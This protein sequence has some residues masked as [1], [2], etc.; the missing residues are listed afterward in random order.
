MTTDARTLVADARR[1]T[2]LTGAGIST[3]SGIPDFRGPN[4]LWTANPGAARMFDIDAYLADRDLRVQAWRNRH[5]HPAWT[6]QPNAAHHAIA[7]LERQGRLRGLIT[8]NIDELHQA[9]GSGT[10]AP[11]MEVHGSIKRAMC[12]SCGRRVPMVDVLAR[13]GAG[14]EDPRCEVCHGILKSDTISFGQ[15]LDRATLLAAAEAAAE[16]EVFLAV[17]SSLRVNPVAGLV[18]LAHES[19]AAV[20][21]VNAEP[22]PYDALAAAVLRDPIEAV[23]PTLVGSEG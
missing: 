16:C 19:G 20:V 22:T 8:Q 23:L 13:V 17:G 4:G 18:P 6:A 9:A 15:A 21:I 12:L 7:D 2:V 1:V 14:E 3:A 10:H 5:E 11:L